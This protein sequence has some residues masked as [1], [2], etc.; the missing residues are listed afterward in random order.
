[1]NKAF[2]SLLAAVCA[3]G[4]C[5]GC[6]SPGAPLPPSLN[7]P[8]PVNDLTA[9][10]KGDRV[11]LTWTPPVS[12]T[13]KG[14]IRGSVVTRVCEAVNE[15]P[16]AS[17]EKVIKELRAS[18][19]PSS[20][21]EAKNPK[22]SVEGAFPRERLNANSEATFAI[23]VLNDR[24]RGAGFSN[25]VIVSLAPALPPPT[26]VTASV[27]PQ[28]VTI[29]FIGA[30]ASS[31]PPR[32]G[33][34]YT[35]ELWR[36]PAGNGE[37]VE[38]ES[39]APSG[40]EQRIADQSFEWEQTYDYKL[41]GITTVTIPGKLPIEVPG[42]DSQV[43]RVFVHDVFPPHAPTGVQAVFSSVGQRPFVDLS[44][45]PNMEPDLAGY[46]VYRK[47][48]GESEQKL[49]K[50]LLKAPSFRDENVNPGET[51]TYTIDAVD[52]RGNRS[53][54]SAESTEYIPK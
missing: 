25:Q 40:A 21:P 34:S 32:P 29:S 31:F 37:Y 11:A 7:L 1:M 43:V 38:V 9:V 19:L 17:C 15:F 53:S 36:R 12:T 13:D 8:R 18:D 45:D 23:E 26:S 22:V 39:V 3:L 51:Y 42:D 6:A 30:A 41:M 44:W 14:P 48:K 5:A 50:E 10:R 52:V 49:N 24:G 16:M 54:R 35:Y 47:P 27:G 46:D 4:V 33:V 28:G 20:A 2:T